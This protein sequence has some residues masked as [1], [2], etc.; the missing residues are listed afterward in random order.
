LSTGTF[1]VVNVKNVLKNIFRGNLGSL[2][3]FD[4]H[5]HDSV[6]SWSGDITVVQQDPEPKNNFLK[7]LDDEDNDNDDERWQLILFLF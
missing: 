3:P 2:N 6:N 5:Q 7:M 1:Q 4:N